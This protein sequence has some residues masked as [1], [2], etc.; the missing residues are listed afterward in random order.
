MVIGGRWRERAGQE[1]RWEGKEGSRIR[2]GEK[3]ER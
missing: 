2:F 1:R 3:Q